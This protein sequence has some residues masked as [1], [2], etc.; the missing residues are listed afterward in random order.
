L[1][2][3]LV[4]QVNY[5]KVVTLRK[6]ENLIDKFCFNHLFQHPYIDSPVL[7]TSNESG[8]LVIRPFS[9]RGTIRDYICKCKPKGQFLKKYAN[10]LKITSL[11]ENMIKIVSK[12]ILETLSLLHEK[13]LPYGKNIFN[14][15]IKK[16]PNIHVCVLVGHLISFRGLMAK[17]LYI[18]LYFI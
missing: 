8:G 7:S 12:Q 13:G 2:T 9:E 15:F 11:D 1:Q 18:T 4:I 3:A 14:F 10:P 17:L 16:S 6:N 5:Q